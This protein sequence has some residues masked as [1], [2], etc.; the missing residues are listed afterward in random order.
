MK[1]SKYL[2]LAGFALLIASCSKD[3][4]WNTS[5][6]VTVEMANA[7]MRT[8]E[9]VGIFKVP[10]VV[11]GKANGPI[12]VTVEVEEIAESPAVEDVHFLITSK[13]VTIPEDASE[14]SIEVLAVNDMEE[15]DDRMF[16]LTIVKAEGA[17]IGEQ[18]STVITIRD[19]EGLPYEAIQ[20][21][22]TF[23]GMNFFDDVEEIPYTMKISGIEDDNDPDYEK[24]LYF[25]GFGG[26]P[27][28]ACEAEFEE[29]AATGEI[30]IY[31]PYGQKLGQLNFTGLGPCDVVLYGVNGQYV[32]DTGASV[33]HVSADMRTITVDRN[34][35]WFYAVEQDGEY[36]GGWD[37][38]YYI[39]LT[40]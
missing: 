13:T 16:V 22:W 35:T 18:N 3:S 14:V 12:K 17:T 11:D 8:K 19:D 32:Q 24:V 39:T 26:V 34:D 36:L 31:I 23:N 2:L 15:N 10:V 20:G 21:D 38:S 33:L 9:N 7:T 6:D 30:T 29:D 28:L 1:F 4:D 37:G 27:A 5:S 25:S 40:R